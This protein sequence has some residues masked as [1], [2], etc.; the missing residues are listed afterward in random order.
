MAV[1][2]RIVNSINLTNL[3]CSYN[4]TN[5]SSTLVTNKKNNNYNKTSIISKCCIDSTV[6]KELGKTDIQQ[7]LTD[8]AKLNQEILVLKKCNSFLEDKFQVRF[9]FIF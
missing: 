5:I 7:C 6:N 3:N 8:I 2:S 4:D 9:I 1:K